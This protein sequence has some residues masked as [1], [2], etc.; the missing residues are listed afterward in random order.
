MIGL[1]TALRE[2][3]KAL[4]SVFGLEPAGTLG[5]LEL[6]V[7]QGCVHLCT[8]MGADR[9]VGG[10]QLLAR[11]YRPDLL[12]LVGFSVGLT[13]EATLGTV[14]YDPR[15][16][17][18]VVG[19]LEHKLKEGRIA[20]CGF[21]NTESQKKAFAEKHPDCLLADLESEAFLQAFQEGPPVLVVRVVSD[22]VKTSLPLDFSHYT[23]KDGFP[24]QRAL[25]KKV[26]FN[27]LVL[28]K[29]IRLARDAATATRS[30]SAELNELK[31]LLLGFGAEQS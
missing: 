29:M 8:G 9:V 31:P 3:R 17:S 18:K 30:L 2:E 12:L 28:P 11:S 20:T 10:A 23:T 19:L 6:S 5:G 15:S 22:D 7:G 1:V 21:L 14:A 24:N 16:S 13:L 25:A 27:P 4:K 26:A